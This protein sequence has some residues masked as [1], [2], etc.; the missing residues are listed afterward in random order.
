MVMAFRYKGSVLNSQGQSVL[1]PS[2][3]LTGLQP[4]SRLLTY[5]NH[6]ATVLVL[7]REG[8][9]AAFFREPLYELFGGS[10]PLDAL[11]PNRELAE[12]EDQLAEAMTNCE[13]I[14]IVERFLRSKLKWPSSD[15]LLIQAVAKIQAERGSTVIHQL[16]RGQSN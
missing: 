1:P 4:S 10:L 5:I 3:V 9:A 14:R 8:G 2:S 16:G 11:I 15:Q 6:T 12:V 13:R 7:F